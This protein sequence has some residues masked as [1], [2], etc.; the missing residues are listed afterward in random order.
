MSYLITRQNHVRDLLVC[1]GKAMLV[2]NTTIAKI[3]E[4][5]LGNSNIGRFHNFF[6]YLKIKKDAKKQ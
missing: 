4:E 5:V 1:V 2:H 6:Y 3:K